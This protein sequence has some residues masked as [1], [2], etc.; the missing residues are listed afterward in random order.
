MLYRHPGEGTP[1]QDVTKYTGPRAAQHP[2]VAPKACFLH[3]YPTRLRQWEAVVHSPANYPIQVP[4]GRLDA[5]GRA[6]GLALRHHPGGSVYVRVCLHACE[7]V[8]VHVCACARECLCA[9]AHVYL[10]VLMLM[11]MYASV[12]MNVYAFMFVCVC[13]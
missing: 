10:C 3:A 5:P 9:H 8:C 13:V 4:H 7:N 11:C 1:H 2:K 12:C 6:A